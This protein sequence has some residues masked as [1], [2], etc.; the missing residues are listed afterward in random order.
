MQSGKQLRDCALPLSHFA[1]HN[2]VDDSLSQSLRFFLQIHLTLV[3]NFGAI[4][5]ITPEFIFPGLIVG[6]VG[7]WIGHIF[8]KTQLPVKREVSIAKAPV[9]A[10]V[11]EALAGLG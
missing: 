1:H 10:A 4:L 11:N 7:F 3:A 9:L 5:S 2:T 8:V 6:A